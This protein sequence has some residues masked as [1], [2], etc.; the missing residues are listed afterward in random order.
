MINFSPLKL[1]KT[2]R[3][4]FTLTEIVVAVAIV[5]LLSA[6]LFPAFGRARESSRQGHCAGNLHNI[7]LATR[8]YREDFQGYPPNLEVLLPAGSVLVATSGDRE[9][10]AGITGDELID[11]LTTAMGGNSKTGGGNGANK[12]TATEIG[13]ESVRNNAVGYLK[14]LDE[15]VCPSDSIQLNGFSSSYGSKI[16]SVW[17]FYGL[18]RLGFL[19]QTIPAA[20][21]LVD[22]SQPYN[23]RRNPAKYSLANRFAPPGTI[24]TH[25][26]FHRAA[27]S[28]LQNPYAL[29]T[30]AEGGQGQ[31]ASDILLRLDGTAKQRDVSAF[32]G[33]KEDGT[34][35]NWQIQTF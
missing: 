19:T 12:G 24:V 30:D 27:S 15:V 34:D 4:G 17:N 25:C 14:S 11:P 16:G 2:R 22:P 26:I 32:T 23:V 1:Q 18:D 29:A 21:L 35:S 20:P 33:T 8:Q 28:K 7:Y 13:V 5:G 10:L 3:Q 6:I 31:G 9:P